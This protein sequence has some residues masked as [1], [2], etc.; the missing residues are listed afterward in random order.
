MP[1]FSYGGPILR[2]DEENSLRLKNV[3]KKNKFEARSFLKLSNFYSK[4]K[5][6]CIVELKA[7]QEEQFK[8]FKSQ[9]RRKLRKTSK[10]D[11][12]TLHGGIEL[13]D[14]F[15]KVFSKKMLEKGS[16]PLGKVFFEN[17]LNEYKYGK[18]QITVVYMD[19]NVAAAGFTLSYLG[20]N[21]MCWASSNK[22]YD[23]YNANSELYWSMIKDSIS[24]GYEHFSM[25]RS[26]VN[27]GNHYYKKQWSPI[28]MPIYF[29]Y[30]EPVGRS[31]KEFGNYNH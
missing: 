22:K 10:Y 19:G 7:S 9:M 27:S 26:T 28:E 23:K 31:L 3:L 20:F 21:E 29:N 18:V 2:C 13:L 24:N 25:G 14:D 17:L 4:K 30:S 12:N 1:H 16:P 8:L 11:F 5:V 6:T 15:Y